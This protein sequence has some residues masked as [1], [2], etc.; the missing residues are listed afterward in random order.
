MCV[1]IVRSATMK[2][3]AAIWGGVINP[4]AP[5]PTPSGCTLKG[6]LPSPATAPTTLPPVAASGDEQ[7]DD[8]VD[9]AK[10]STLQ[11]GMRI[12]EKIRSAMMTEG[13]TRRR[14][15]D[16]VLGLFYGPL[17][18]DGY[19][20]EGDEEESD[21]SPPGVSSCATPPDVDFLVFMHPS[22]SVPVHTVIW[23]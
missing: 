11:Y 2:G 1:L 10:D 22:N 4:P 12:A 21:D 14:E 5:I 9:D 8:M 16:D 20:D 13:R 7:L 18:D 17:S 23:L 15:Q 19:K 3:T 6:F